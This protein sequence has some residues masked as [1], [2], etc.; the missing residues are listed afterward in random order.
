MIAISLAEIGKR[1][2]CQFMH[3]DGL[4]EYKDI[5]VLEFAT[6][7][8]AGSHSPMIKICDH[9]DNNKVRWLSRYNFYTDEEGV[10][11]R[12]NY[13]FGLVDELPP[14]TYSMYISQTPRTYGWID[15]LVKMMTGK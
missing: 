7:V 10:Y 13:D 1:Y 3:M 8:N 11:R 4:C 15:S 5:T 12:T 2:M 14:L 6:I 9:C